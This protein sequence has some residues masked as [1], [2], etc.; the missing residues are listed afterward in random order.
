MLAK[1]KNFFP[2]PT[3]VTYEVPRKVAGGRC[4]LLFLFSLGTR[5]R[6]STKS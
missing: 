6:S 1:I 2:L 5:A 4:R 3:E